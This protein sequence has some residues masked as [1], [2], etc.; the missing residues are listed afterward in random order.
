MRSV[1]TGENA[2]TSARGAWL[3]Q[4]S[5]QGFNFSGGARGA[6]FP[7]A[8]RRSLGGEAETGL[9]VTGLFFLWGV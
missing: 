2:K 6:G 5:C 7:E 1:L 8:L 9:R 3:R 4:K